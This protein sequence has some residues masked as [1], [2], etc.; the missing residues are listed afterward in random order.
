MFASK[1]LTTSIRKGLQR[2]VFSSTSQTDV[3]E[4]VAKWASQP[5]K[6]FMISGEVT[7]TSVYNLAMTLNGDIGAHSWVYN[8]ASGTHPASHWLTAPVSMS[9]SAL[10]PDGY[11]DV[12]ISPA[13]APYD[14]RMWAG[15][16]IEW[17]KP[18]HI[19]Q[20]V[21]VVTAVPQDPVFKR[22]KSGEMIFVTQDTKWVDFSNGFFDPYVTEKVN[23]VFRDSTA[24]KMKIAEPKT[25]VDNPAPLQQGVD[26]DFERESLPLNEILLFRYSALSWNSHRIHY[27]KD[28][29]KRDG[30]P[31]VLVHGPLQ[32]TLLLDLA[33]TVSKHIAGAEPQWSIDLKQ[34]LQKRIQAERKHSHGHSH[35]H[36]ET[37]NHDHDEQIRTYPPP[38]SCAQSWFMYLVD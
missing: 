26:F 22:G 8:G 6:S 34:E 4:A 27:D 3:P 29:A 23:Y 19:G 30:Y 31:N 16:E 28:F 18:M 15:G 17:H 14:A 38:V 10:N 12:G 2:R 25:T 7:H 21:D 33:G 24:N 9:T 13:P 5:R 37:C 11:Q 36:G 20:R 1:H 35:A 32:A